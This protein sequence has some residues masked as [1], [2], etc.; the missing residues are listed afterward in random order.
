MLLYTFWKFG[1]CP[2]YSDYQY[3]YTTDTQDTY[4]DLPA[5]TLEVCVADKPV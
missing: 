4:L 1:S 3:F 2:M 5:K